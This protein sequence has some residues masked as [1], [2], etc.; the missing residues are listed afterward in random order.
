MMRDDLVT[1]QD[2]IGATRPRIDVI[3]V[4]TQNS[5]YPYT[6]EKQEEVFYHEL[7]HVILNEMD[8]HF[9]SEEVEEHFTICFSKLLNQ[10]LK[11]RKYA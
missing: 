11:T 10:T 4:Q 7:T 8:W 1:D 5:S 9:E 6:A 2:A 3:H